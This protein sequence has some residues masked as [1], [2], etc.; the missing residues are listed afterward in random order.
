MYT[1]ELA[2]RKN[3]FHF[4]HRLMGNDDVF[5]GMDFK[6]ILHSFNINDVRKTDPVKF[7]VRSDKNMFPVNWVLF[8]RLAF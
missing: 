5:G 7:T 6:I 4:N 2:G 1:D 3:I 8:H